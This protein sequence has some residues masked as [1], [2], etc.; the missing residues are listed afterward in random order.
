M[1]HRKRMA[2]Y[3][4]PVNLVGSVEQGDQR[5]EEQFMHKYMELK[6]VKETPK[7]TKPMDATTGDED[8]DEEPVDDEM[9]KFADAEMEK[10][11]K[12]MAQGAPGGMP[13][14]DEED[15]S[16]DMSGGEEGCPSVY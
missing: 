12:R 8:D 13:D 11:M 4:Q 16:L 9:E 14:S 15:V 5:L 6:P 1:K 3:E 2:Q 7:S 10:E